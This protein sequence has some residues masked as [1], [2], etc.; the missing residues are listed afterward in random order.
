MLSYTQRRGLFGDLTNNAIAAHLTLG[1]TLLNSV[2]R[3]IMNMRSWWF[4]FASPTDTTVASQA[5]YP[6]PG[7]C[8][9][10]ISA[11]YIT[12]SSTRYT[13]KRCPDRATWDK[14]NQTS[15]T[16]DIPEWFYIYADD[17]YFYPAPATAGNTITF[18]CRKKTKDLSTADYTTGTVDIITNGDTSV[19]GSGTTWAATHVGSYIKLATPKGDNLW[20]EIS[21]FTSATV[22]TL[23]R[24]Y[25]GTSQTTGAAI[26]Y[27]I[28]EMSG[29]PEGYD[30][31]SV[32]RACELYF[33][34][35]KPD[36]TKAALYKNLAAEL[37]SQLIADHGSTTDIAG[38]D[39]VDILMENPNL[40]IAL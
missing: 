1:D 26:S 17:V 34:S 20:Y 9:K 38:I 31:I 25:A 16:G 21:A 11:P 15:R 4:L 30:E 39:D 13:P 40:H 24:E 12:V 22:I 8:A 28:G 3:Q 19:T 35:I 33:T 27:I 2:T 7:N 29:L 6:L 23:A 36:K 18:P 10:L 37:L 14:L 32:Y 5:N